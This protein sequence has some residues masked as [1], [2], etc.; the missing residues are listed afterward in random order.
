MPAPASFALAISGINWLFWPT[1]I[2]AKMTENTA[3]KTARPLSTSLFWN[4]TAAIKK[5]IPS[6]NIII[7]LLIPAKIAA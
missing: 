1:P 4:K 2:A 6:I 7:P 5:M 3:V